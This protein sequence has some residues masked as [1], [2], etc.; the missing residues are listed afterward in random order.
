MANSP[1]HPWYRAIAREKILREARATAK[2]LRA[3]RYRNDNLEERRT[4][5]RDWHRLKLGIPLEAPVMTRQEAQVRS[6]A[7]RKLNKIMSTFTPNTEGIWFDLPEEVYRAA[8]GVNQSLLKSAPTPAHYKARLEEPFEVTDALLFGRLL[9]TRVFDCPRF[10][11]EVIVRPEGISFTTKEG[12]AW[13]DDLGCEST[14]IAGPSGFRLLTDGRVVVTQRILDRFKGMGDALAA[15]PDVQ[16]VVANAKF[17]V[18][19][20]KVDPE[21][22][23]L[24]KGRLDIL[25]TDD[26]QFTTVADLKTC[27]DAGDEAMGRAIATYGYD[28]Q[29]KFYQ[30]LVG[31]TYHI[32]ICVEKESPYGVRVLNLDTESIDAAKAVIR[33]KLGAIALAQQTGEWPCYPTGITTI[34]VPRWR[35]RQGGAT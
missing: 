35:L 30:D 19:A 21:T 3:T 20:F 25:T 32:L 33:R 5:E 12:R 10:E 24:M 27:E 9:D 29:A 4:R 17:Q 31:A 28:L 22:G 26:N 16:R 23:L 8:P 15:H 11:R 14:T 7:A 6:V 34:N 1:N 13:L 18:S 2:K